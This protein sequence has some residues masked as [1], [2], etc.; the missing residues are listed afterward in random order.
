MSYIENI[1]HEISELNAKI[2]VLRTE[3][4][5]K[6]QPLITNLVKDFL[7]KYPKVENI[8]WTQYTPYFNDGE[9]CIFGVNEIYLTIE[10]DDDV[11]DYEGSQLY[12]QRDL[13]YYENQLKIAENYQR[14]PSVYIAEKKTRWN[15]VPKPYYTIRE[16]ENKIGEIRTFFIEHNVEQMKKDFDEVRTGINVIDEEYMKDIYGDHVKVV[17]SRNGTF[18]DEYDHD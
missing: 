1:E 16:A 6:A 9:E 8:F 15:P 7:D 10:G 14:D 17:I 12:T 2:E 13:D 3:M 5:N 11:D 18:V 4:R